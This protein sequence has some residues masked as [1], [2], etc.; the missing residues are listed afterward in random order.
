MNGH[1]GAPQPTWGR[2]LSLLWFPFFFAAVMSL[3]YVAGISHP[4]PRA[5]HLGVLHEAPAVVPHG[6]EIEQVSGLDGVRAD[7]LA[8]VYDSAT[9]TLYVSSAGS[10]TRADYLTAV[11]HPAHTVDL[12]PTASGDVTGVGL[13]F[14]GLPLLLVGMITS[15]MMLQ[16]GMWPMRRKIVTIAATGAFTSVFS[17]GVAVWRDVIPAD[18]RLLVYGFLLTQAIG[19]ITTALPRFV[20]QFTMPVA[21]TL[22][23]LLGLPTA[24]GTVNADMM[25]A[26]L[27]W[28]HNVLPFGQFIEVARSSAYFG[29]HGLARP[30]GIL[31]GWVVVA[32]ALLAWAARPVRRPAAVA[33]E[34][35]GQTLHGT[36]RTT[37]GVPVAGATVLT[38]DDDGRELVRTTTGADGAYRAG[39]VRPGLHHLVVTAAHHEPEIVTIGVHEHH[40]GSSRDITLIDWDDPAGTLT[41]QE[42]DERRSLVG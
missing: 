1:A 18:W 29:G 13:F 14:Y 9:G 3:V 32:A 36:V 41:P 4:E 10:G 8:G 19:W 6:V 26:V 27:R 42:V 30:L 2:V 40:A 35:P 16:F 38:L 39:N 5:V 20:K 25:P 12:V 15:F 23:L 37:S 11:L 24:G 22:V 21:M 7:E 28:L 17:Y 34:K 33:E 31:I